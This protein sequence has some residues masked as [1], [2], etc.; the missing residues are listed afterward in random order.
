MTGC[1]RMAELEAARDGRLPAE[2][3]RALAQHAQSCLQCRAARAE[4]E[5]LSRLAT[6]LPAHTPDELAARRMRSRVMGSALMGARTSPSAMKGR[7]VALAALAA[8]LML[9]LGGLV[10]HRDRPTPTTAATVQHSPDPGPATRRV[11]LG[12]AGWLWPADNARVLVR[13]AGADTHIDLWHGAITLAVRR[14]REGERFV[15]HVRDDEV[16]V[17]GTRFTVTADMGRL[18][19]VDVAEGLVAVRHAGDPERLLGA[20]SHLILPAPE[21]AVVPSE[22]VEPV[23]VRTTEPVETT[24]PRVLPDPGTWFREGSFAYARGEHA[25]AVRAL[26]RFL[27]AAPRRDPRREDARYLHILSLQAL[28]RVDALTRAG[29]RY[30]TEFP[31]G[32]RRAEVVLVMAQSLASAGR[33]DEAARV[34]RTLPDDAPAATRSTLARVLRCTPRSPTP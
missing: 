22:P 3:T 31:A 23:P 9:V 20:A 11:E 8:A 28:D 18:V 17:R 33:C 5:A 26:E 6:Q 30:R 16:E 19:R 25:D 2:A 14:R 10:R 29:A 12:G 21:V 24:R 1:A 13:S 34:G 4:L 15:V 27:T 7:H 32:V